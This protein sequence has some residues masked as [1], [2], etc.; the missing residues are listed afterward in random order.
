[1]YLGIICQIHSNPF[2]TIGKRRGLLLDFREIRRLNW[3]IFRNR[4]LTLIYD[5]QLYHVC[6]LMFDSYRI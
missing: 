1:M 4:K 5:D 3:T 6:M 2:I